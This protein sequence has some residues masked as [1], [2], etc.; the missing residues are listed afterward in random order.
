M[1][2]VKVLAVLQARTTSTRLPGKVLLPLVGAPM[3]LRQIERIKRAKLIDKIVVATSDERSD[4]ELAT[5]CQNSDVE[6][7]RGNLDDVLDRF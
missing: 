3:I 4:D 1:E 7:Y 2:T 6:V 5:V